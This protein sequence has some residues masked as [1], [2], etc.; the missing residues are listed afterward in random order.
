MSEIKKN[1]VGRP[2]VNATPITVRV[3]PDML[4]A[5][6]KLAEALEGSSRPHALRFALQR[7]MEADGFISNKPRIGQDLLINLNRHEAA[8]LKD[9]VGPNLANQQEAVEGLV[10]VWLHENGY[11]PSSQE[12]TRP[13]DLN[14]SNDD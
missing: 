13:E 7:Y 12:G 14:A 2:A 10:R 6:D 1:P 8:A 3:P 11:L 4:A 9:A 5:L